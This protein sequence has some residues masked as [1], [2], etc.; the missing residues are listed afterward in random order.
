MRYQFAVLWAAQLPLAVSLVLYACGGAE[1]APPTTPVREVATSAVAFADDRSRCDYKNRTDRTV[2]E[3]ASANS[4]KRNIRRV[5][6]VVGTGEDARRIL[7][8]REVD[9]NLDGVKDVVRTYNDDGDALHEIAD[10]DFDGRI[11]IWLTF[12]GGRIAE[13]RRDRNGDGVPDEKRAYVAGGKIRAEFDDNADGKPD[14]REIY[15]KGR[16]QRRGIDLDGDGTI[17]RWDRDEVAVRLADEKE[18]AEAERAEAEKEE[19]RRK[20]NAADAGVTDAGEGGQA[21]IDNR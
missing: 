10:S 20:Q 14:A 15:D 7:L 1:T 6:G 8:C 16:L 4:E 18:R 11:D 5:Y 9:T 17:D 12:A 13:L 2:V 3:T 19:R 21:S